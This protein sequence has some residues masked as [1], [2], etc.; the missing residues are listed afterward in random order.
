MSP[1][2]YRRAMELWDLL[3]GARLNASYRSIA[4]DG[5]RGAFAGLWIGT[6]ATFMIWLCAKV[7]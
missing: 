5:Q 1:L 3:A 7:S 4:D 6:M 2:P